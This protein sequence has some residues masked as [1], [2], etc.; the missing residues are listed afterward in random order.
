MGFSK[1]DIILLSTALDNYKWYQ[2]L[3]DKEKEQCVK[4]KRILI[5]LYKQKERLK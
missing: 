5:K 2:V 3:T 4:L 1:D